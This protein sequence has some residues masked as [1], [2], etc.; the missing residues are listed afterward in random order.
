MWEWAVKK[1]KRKTEGANWWYD[2]AMD[3]NRSNKKLAISYNK[4]LKIMSAVRPDLSNL[5]EPHKDP[6]FYGL[7]NK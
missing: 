7:W 6:G 1:G 5:L 4:E 2:S 3:R